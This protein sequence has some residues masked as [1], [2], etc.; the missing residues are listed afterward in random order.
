M[1]KEHIML[2]NFYAP[3][4][5][6]FCLSASLPQ[7]NAMDHE[8]KSRSE[9]TFVHATGY[10]NWTTNA[11]PQRRQRDTYADT[12]SYTYLDSI[13]PASSQESYSN[14]SS[15]QESDSDENSCDINLISSPSYSQIVLPI[16]KKTTLPKGYILLEDVTNR[17]GI[18][19]SELA[20]SR[21]SEGRDCAA[22]AICSGMWTNALWALSRLYDLAKST[23]WGERN[24][25]AHVIYYGIKG[26]ATWAAPKLVE[27]EKSENWTEKNTA[28]Q[29]L[30]LIV[31]FQKP[32]TLP[33][34]FIQAAIPQ[35]HYAVQTQCG[36]IHYFPQP[37]IFQIPQLTPFMAGQTGSISCNNHGNGQPTQNAMIPYSPHIPHMKSAPP[38]LDIEAERLQRKRNSL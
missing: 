29:V 17:I 12:Y 3:L 18:K 9:T 33:T 15:S 28:R 32:P 22:Q 14:E 13:F 8:A 19:T 26:K 31:G 35:P 16:E 38:R 4:F 7:A 6:S 27:F 1:P 21:Y 23:R 34:Q 30:D 11:M 25:A 5:A 37:Q 24:T 2:N 20:R 10:Q 36:P